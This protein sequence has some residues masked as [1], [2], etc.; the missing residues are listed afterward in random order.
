MNIYSNLSQ[1]ALKYLKDTE[2]I[3]NNVLIMT[4][5][6]NIHNN[7]WNPKYPYHSIHSDLLIDIVDSIH[8][9]LLFS[10]NYVSTRYS[11]N[12]CNSNSVIDLMFLRYDSEELD[13]HS[14]YSE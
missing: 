13:N 4:R 3:I 7:F 8:L 10:L 11:N 6:F 12:N 2:V 9:G 5:Y 14:I 1:L